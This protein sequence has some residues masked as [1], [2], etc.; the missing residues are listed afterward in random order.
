MFNS[1][2]PIK[3]FT[4]LEETV[5]EITTGANLKFNNLKGNGRTSSKTRQPKD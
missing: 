2:A 5:R 1:T 4:N 3:F